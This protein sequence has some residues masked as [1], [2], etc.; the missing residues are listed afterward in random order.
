M[1]LPRGQAVTDLRRSEPGS[2]QVLMKCNEACRMV[3]CYESPSIYGRIHVDGPHASCKNSK[4]NNTTD[5][6]L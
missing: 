2:F 6:F 4:M 3:D 1:A 5:G